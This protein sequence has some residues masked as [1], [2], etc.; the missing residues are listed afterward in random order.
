M[1]RRSTCSRVS[2][3]PKTSAE[4]IITFA[5]ASW[6]S[7]SAAGSVSARPARCAQASASS[8]DVP[9]AMLDKTALTV[10]LSTPRSA[11][12][13]APARPSVSALSTGVP[14]MTVDSARNATLLA[15]RLRGELGAAQG[16]RP[17]VGGD[18]RDPAPERFPHVGQAGLAIA[19]R[20]RRHLH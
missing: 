7:T 3:L 6:P 9:S 20:A 18:H 17:L 8:Y 12:G 2:C 14:D 19:R 5:V 11:T 1:P 13:A 4:R 10:A 15:A 16:N